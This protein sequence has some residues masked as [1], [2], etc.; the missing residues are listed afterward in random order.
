[1]A[2]GAIDQ[3]QH[4]ALQRFADTRR[5]EAEESEIIA[6]ASKHLERAAIYITV[7]VLVVGLALISIGKLD[8]IVSARGSI[9]PRSELVP[10]QSRNTGVVSSV[11]VAA[12]D[13]VKA[14]QLMMR[15]GTAITD[16]DLATLERQLQLATDDLSRKQGEAAALDQVAP[17]FTALD[18][19]DIDLSRF[20]AAIDL[21]NAV[22][23][24]A[25]DLKRTQ[26]LAGDDLDRLK[27]QTQA[28]IAALDNTIAIRQQNLAVAE[29]E[30]QTLA[31]S[32][33]LRQQQL[34]GV[35]ELLAKGIS[36]KTREL[37]VRDQA[38]SA[39][40]AINGQ[41]AKI[42]DLKLAIAN[43][44]LQMT[45]LQ[46]G[47]GTET[48]KRRDAL[49]QTER[50]LSGAKAAV[51]TYRTKLAADM[52]ALQA[53]ILKQQDDLRL[54]RELAAKLEIRAPVDGTVASLAF[55]A[56]GS[57]VEEGA[58]VARIVPAGADNIVTTTLASKDVGRVRIGEHAAV[59]LDAY[60]FYRFGTV[61]AT[62]ASV[63]PL[64]GS[65]LFAVR[66]N[67]DRETIAVAGKARPIAAGLEA[68]VEI[69]TERRS[70]LAILFDRGADALSGGGGKEKAV[71]SAETAQP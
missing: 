53:D 18:R 35:R 4:E 46:L 71:A 51:L 61:P 13:T 57:R 40:T 54:K 36:T 34:A 28:R 70:I 37:E 58:E 31:E 30:L 50:T 66:L 38:L 10:V 60:P 62:V 16:A 42:G 67:L 48:E 12:G 64:P 41:Q 27:Q 56:P 22:R 29:G 23:I 32:L 24:A 8:V 1:M 19:N 2:D 11:L 17:D 49:F 59:K 69:M 52:H 43:D 63:F 33:T 25:L 3:S 44:R 20:G 26:H 7:L 45:E 5:Q 9:E 39:E 68:T 47:L 65:R 6:P 55:P 21:V 15:L 14:G